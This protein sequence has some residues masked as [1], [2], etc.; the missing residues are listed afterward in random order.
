MLEVSSI[1]IFVLTKPLCWGPWHTFLGEMGRSFFICRDHFFTVEVVPPTDGHQE[2]LHQ[3]W[4]L[5]FQP[6][7]ET[8]E[9]PRFQ[10]WPRRIRGGP[11]SSSSR[12]RLTLGTTCWSPWAL[13]PTQPTMPTFAFL[14]FHEGIQNRYRL[15][16]KLK[17]I[18]L[19][20][21][22]SWQEAGW[23]YATERKKMTLPDSPVSK[24]K[25]RSGWCPRTDCLP[26][27]L[28]RWLRCA[29]RVH[30]GT[31][32]TAPGYEYRW[33]VPYEPLATPFREIVCLGLWKWGSLLNYSVFSG[34]RRN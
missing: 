18:H 7:C 2:F 9:L 24:V 13:G 22:W 34:Q 27:S 14:N 4:M 32:G 21:P 15:Q 25:K 19:I 30:T 17:N 11:W 1:L 20:L 26:N 16:H 3:A 31:L 10:A 29:G 23:E 12:R 33:P 8:R 6:H 5:P 28:Q